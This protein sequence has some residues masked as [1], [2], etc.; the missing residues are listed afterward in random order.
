MAYLHGVEVVEGKPKPTPL[1]LSNQ[2][3]IGIIGVAPNADVEK[4]PL[5]S[6]VLI[7]G[8]EEEAAAL[9]DEGSLPRALKCIFQ[10]CLPQMVIVR[11]VGESEADVLNALLGG[12]DADTD[13]YSGVHVFKES[14]GVLGI[15][16]KILVAPGYSDKTAVANEL[17]QVADTLKATVVLD[18]PNTTDAEAIAYVQEFAGC[19]NVY[20]I[21]PAVKV[22]IATGFESFV[23]SPYVAAVMA[24]QSYAESPSNVVIKGVSGLSR[25]VDY[26]HGDSH[27]RA[28]LLN[29]KYVATII[30]EDGFRIW[31]NR[32]AAGTFISAYRIR[33]YMTEGL[34]AIF[35]PHVDRGLTESKVEYL[36]IQ[37]NKFLASMVRDDKALIYGTAYAPAERNTA[38]QRRQ[39]RLTVL[40]DY[41]DV[42]PMER[43]TI[44]LNYE[45]EE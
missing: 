33:D 31:G 2:G 19:E 43:V 28:N 29:E 25:E 30:R 42:T 41:E 27:C 40:V 20:V 36:L 14:K 15:A 7:A 4:F 35:F 12:Y 34:N 39:G 8:S 23:S 1:S 9:G 38:D 26:R 18:G 21:D 24:S 10:Q 3:V 44:E 5:D 22:A 16:P 32:A 11:V 37:A 45:P 17:R 6:P 13:K